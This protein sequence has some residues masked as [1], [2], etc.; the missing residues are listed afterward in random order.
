MLYFTTSTTDPEERHDVSIG[1]AKCAGGDD[2]KNEITR[3]VLF[4]LFSNLVI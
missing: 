4:S 1:A 3:A 2:G